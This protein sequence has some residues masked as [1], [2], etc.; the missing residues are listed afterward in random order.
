MT[1]EKVVVMEEYLH[2][3]EKA[4]TAQIR[5]DIESTLKTLQKH[6]DTPVYQYYKI[7]YEQIRD[8]R[9]NT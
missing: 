2:I 3:F 5:Y 6:Y 7:R 1:L 9:R 4:D 8:S